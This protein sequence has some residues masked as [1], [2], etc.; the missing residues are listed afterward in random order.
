MS[1]NKPQYTLLIVDDDPDIIDAL[2]MRYDTKYAVLTA[3]YV[4]EAIDV[5]K[6]SGPKIDVV[7]LDLTMPITADD[8][9]KKKD[10]GFQVHSEARVYAPES[11]FVALTANQDT[12]IEE[13]VLLGMGTVIKG[14]QGYLAKLDDWIQK[15]CDPNRRRYTPIPLRQARAVVNDS[16]RL[17][18][19]EAL[20]QIREI[21]DRA[22]A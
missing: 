19:Q 13:L 15:A 21:L 12:N 10:A 7:I 11:R 9:G 8:P 18:P 6:Q 20:L 3:R 17:S 2:T 22:M 4:A 14:T 1:G 5:L 16:A